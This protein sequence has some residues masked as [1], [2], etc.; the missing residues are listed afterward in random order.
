MAFA[1]RRRDLD[2]T[3]KEWTAPAGSAAVDEAVRL[4]RQDNRT[5]IYVSQAAF[6]RWRSISQITAIGACYADLDYHTRT[7]WRGK[8]PSDVAA[9]VIDRLE[10]VMIPLPSYIL[11]TGRGLVCVWLTE[12][13]PRAVLPRWNAAQRALGAV[14]EP[15]GADKRALD[16]ARVFRLTGSENGRAE[17]DRRTVGMVWCQ[18]TPE[19]PTRHQFATLADEVLPMTQAELVSL[20]V[21]RAKRKAAGKDKTGPSVH[22]SE[23]SYHETVLTDL[24][25][26]RAHRCPEGA[27]PKGQRDAWLFIAG[28]SMSWICPPEVLGR[29]IMTLASEAAGWR[30]SETKSRMSSV[31]KRARQAAAGQMVA[32]AGRDVDCRYRMKASTI[33]E[34]LGIDPT[35]Q[36][37]AGLR[38]LVDEDRK[39]ELSI[40]RMEQSRRRRGV[41]DRQEQ[42][43]VRLEMGRKALYLRSAQGMTRDELAA[44]FGVS[45]GQISKAM[46]EAGG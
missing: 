33:V 36:R 22:L 41:K 11:S 39:R 43:T 10:E 45:A 13:L 24:Q 34:W 9:R 19:A 35:E 17:W 25:R 23:A 31:V 21:E 27:L 5:D 12:L 8:T 42:Q 1:Q 16:A 7:R 18:G 3:W 26:L 37:A 38:V 6:E 20:R 15:F 2:K 32:F 44:H 14:L 28:V 29:E 30:D 40:E 4:L 46:R